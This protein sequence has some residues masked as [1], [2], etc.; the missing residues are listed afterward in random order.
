MIGGTGYVI[1]VT[2]LSLMQYVLFPS[3]YTCDL[4]FIA[5]LYI[6]LFSRK[7]RTVFIVWALGIVRGFF[8]ASF[9]FYPLFFIGLFYLLSYVRERM[10]VPHPL[11][12]FLI[13][14]VVF[15]LYGFSEVLFNM[16][17]PLPERFFLCWGEI[18][19]KGII[20]AA[21]GTAVFWV[22]SNIPVRVV[23]ESEQGTF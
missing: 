22:F 13:I 23:V 17:G 10:R 4:F 3:A 5:G 14:L 15:L 8:S 21:A 1:I 12:Q 2:F 19:I 16:G 20:N 18:W 9:I 6:A 11:T 7:N